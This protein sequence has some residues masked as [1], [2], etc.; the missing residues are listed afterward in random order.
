VPRACDYVTVIRDPVARVVSHYHHVLNE[1]S[2]Y[3]HGMVK[4]RRMTLLQYAQNAVG[5]KELDNGQTRMLADYSLNAQTPVRSGSRTLLE[6]AMHN[7]ETH[8]CA[9]GLTERFDESMVMLAE[10]LGWT[11]IPPY[12]PAR[13]SGRSGRYPLSRDVSEKIREMNGLDAELY[14]WVSARFER[15]AQKY[16]P[17]LEDRVASIRDQNAAAAAALPS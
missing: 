16:G 3:L 6:S 10:S 14:D 5:T 12:L 11:S 9:V 1:T 4:S 15:Q 2:H 8:F 7:I 17:G 13:V